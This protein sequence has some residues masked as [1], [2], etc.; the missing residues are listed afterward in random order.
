M[1]AENKTKEQK[2]KQAANACVLEKEKGESQKRKEENGKT[3]LT[4]MERTVERSEL[5]FIHT[6]DS[7]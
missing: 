3:N 1:V 6:C 4:Y 5:G 7:S 2:R